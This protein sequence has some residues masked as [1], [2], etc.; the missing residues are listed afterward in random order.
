MVWDS[1]CFSRVILF[2]GVF[3]QS[4][5]PASYPDAGFDITADELKC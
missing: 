2:A 1:D 5:P 3:G 4:A